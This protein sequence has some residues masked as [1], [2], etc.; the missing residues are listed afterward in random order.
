M[1]WRTHLAF[2]NCDCHLITNLILT[3]CN[4]HILTEIIKIRQMTSFRVRKC[5]LGVSMTIFY[6]WT[7]KFPKN[8]HFNCDCHLIT[9]LILTICNLHLLTE[10]IKVLWPCSL[11]LDLFV[12]FLSFSAD[13]VSCFCGGNSFPV[14]THFSPVPHPLSPMFTFKS[15][16]I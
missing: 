12:K 10:I 7:L 2:F 9:N 6:V 13:C 1:F 16:H 8:R 3:I 14:L 5:L 11:F 4:L 15:N